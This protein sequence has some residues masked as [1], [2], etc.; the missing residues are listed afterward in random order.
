MS[1]AD[2]DDGYLFTPKEL[3]DL[4]NQDENRYDLHSAALLPK[5]LLLRPLHL[6][7]YSKNYLELLSQHTTV[8]KVSEAMFV[9]QFRKMQSYK[10]I[11]YVVVIEDL[12]NHK[13]IATGTLEIEHKFIHSTALRG[14]IEDVVIDKETEVSDY[15][16]S[17]GNLAQVIMDVVTSLG[18]TLG[19]YKI[20]LESE[21]NFLKFYNNFGYKQQAGQN[22]M[23]V[24]Y[25]N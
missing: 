7:D 20:S 9:E 21:D 11:Y 1:T 17:D 8:G 25:R 12:S 22:Y 4:L 23:A 19:C 10:N 13:I 3:K 14:R 15:R 16:Y 18:K 6:R 2:S 24:R 5:N